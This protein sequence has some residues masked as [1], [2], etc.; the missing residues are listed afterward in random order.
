MIFRMLVYLQYLLLRLNLEKE[1]PCNILW[2]SIDFILKLEE[3]AK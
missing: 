2:I 3:K 1:Q